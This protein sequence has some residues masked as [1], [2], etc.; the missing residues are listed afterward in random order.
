M[1][2]R[3]IVSL[4]CSVLLVGAGCT[5]QTVKTPTA[6]TPAAGQV[7]TTYT[8]PT[9]ADTSPNAKNPGRRRLMTA[10][11]TDGLTFTRTNTVVT[12]Q[13]NVPDLVMDEDG[14]LYLYFSGWEVGDRENAMGVAISEDQ[15]KT[16]TFHQVTISG[17]PNMTNSGDPD[18][19]I[20]KDGTFRLFSTFATPETKTS[21]IFYSE[22]TDGIAFDYGGIAFHGDAETL[23]SN[24]YLVGDT[25]HMYTLVEK[26]TNSFH[27][28]SKNGTTFS[29]QARDAYEIDKLPMVMSNVVAFDGGYR[30]YAFTP[31]PSAANIHSY[32][33]TDGETWAAEDGIRLSLDASSGLESKYVMDPSVIRL[34]DGSYLMVYVT[35]I[36]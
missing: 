20:L 13:A 25:W 22:G 24:T 11:S 33:S 35:Q 36:P 16:W 27:A 31:V 15:G 8:P 1:Q 12:D 21:A 34:T 29:Q 19:V 28:T 23:D 6:T 30:M 17:G 32:W 14:T 3:L 7:D 18:V 9:G 2:S 5:T 4:L 26:T 10:T